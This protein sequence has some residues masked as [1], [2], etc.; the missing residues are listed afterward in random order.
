M[1]WNTCKLF[2]WFFVRSVREMQGMSWMERPEQPSNWWFPLRRNFWV[3][4]MSH[5]LPIAAIA[6][7]FAARNRF[8]ECR[9]NQAGWWFGARWLED[10]DLKPWFLWV[11]LKSGTTT[12]PPGSKAPREKLIHI[13]DPEE[14]VGFLLAPFKNPTKKGYLGKNQRLTR[15][16]VAFCWGSKLEKLVGDFP[17]HFDSRWPGG[18]IDR[19]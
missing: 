7:L 17:R 1:S 4:S 16:S 19:T 14:R 18:R 15:S 8:L 9:T 10:L 2:F 11:H 12:K 5:S 13:G 6:S 3:H